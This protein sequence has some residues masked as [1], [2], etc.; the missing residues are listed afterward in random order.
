MT[1]QP[2][3]QTTLRWAQTDITEVDPDR[4]DTGWWRSHW[5]RTRV[6]GAIVNAA[7]IVA[8]TPPRYRFTTA[9][10]LWVTAT[11]TARSPQRRRIAAWRR[12]QNGLEPRF[13]AP[14]RRAPGLDLSLRR[15][16]AVD[17]G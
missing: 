16:A 6:Q 17:A 1:A 14:C 9:P 11:S 2:W 13:Q 4:Y 5:K 7:G 12:R 3:H 8:T 15:R 10:T